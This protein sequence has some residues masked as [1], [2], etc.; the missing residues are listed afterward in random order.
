MHHTVLSG[1]GNKINFHKGNEYYR[2]LVNCLRLEYVATPKAQKLE[3]GK[4]VV[5]H[6]RSLDPPGRFLTK[7]PKTGKYIDIGERKAIDK[8]RQ[9]LREGA[10]EI[11]SKIKNGEI[12][13]EEVSG[14]CRVGAIEQ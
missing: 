4:L 11:E 14:M 12:V 9:A 1:R 5:E 3:F 7:D 10:P 8:T 2:K 6:I 13:V